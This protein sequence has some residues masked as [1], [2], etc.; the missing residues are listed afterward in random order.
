MQVGDLVKDPRD[1]DIGLIVAVDGEY[2]INGPAYYVWFCSGCEKDWY[3]G[4]DLE[5]ISASR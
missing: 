5:V 3:S 4:T 2:F 1:D